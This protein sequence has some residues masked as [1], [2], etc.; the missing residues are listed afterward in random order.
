MLHNQVVQ[1][2]I[3]Q[4]NWSI[5]HDKELDPADSAFSA[6]ANPSA[7]HRWIFANGADEG[8][9]DS[10]AEPEPEA[11]TS[12]QGEGRAAKNMPLE[13]EGGAAKDARTSTESRK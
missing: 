1:A 7:K 11:R 10:E 9:F 3:A 4:L 2:L 8:S 13:G 6:S 5:D 12:Q